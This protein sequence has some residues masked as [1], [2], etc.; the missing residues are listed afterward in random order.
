MKDH[1]DS[2]KW[3]GGK[4][5]LKKRKRLACGYLLDAVAQRAR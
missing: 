2:M 5:L 4:L 1:Q 3:K